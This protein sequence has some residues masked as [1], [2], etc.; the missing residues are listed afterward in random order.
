MGNP[1]FCLMFERSADQPLIII[2]RIPPVNADFRKPTGM[3]HKIDARTGMKRTPQTW[4][5]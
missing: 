1:S 4:V 3:L 5:F 2:G